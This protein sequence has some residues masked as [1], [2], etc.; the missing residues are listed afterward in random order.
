MKFGNRAT[1]RHQWFY[2]STSAGRLN[3][4]NDYYLSQVCHFLKP[5]ASGSRD[6]LEDANVLMSVGAL[7]CQLQVMVNERCFSFLSFL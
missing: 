3:Q 2:S 6:L 4:Y 7:K 1:R 5:I